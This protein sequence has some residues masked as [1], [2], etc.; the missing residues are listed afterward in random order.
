MT[1]TSRRRDKS[2]D[3]DVLV[4]HWLV[5]ISD[6]ATCNFALTCQDLRFHNFV[7]FAFMLFVASVLSLPYF[8]LQ[9]SHSCIVLSAC[10][11][12]RHLRNKVLVSKKNKTH[13]GQ[14]RQA[15]QDGQSRRHQGHQSATTA[16]GGKRRRAIIKL[17]KRTEEEI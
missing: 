10:V 8:H 6:F 5:F 13:E 3:P 4:S 17:K 9:Y 7:P 15:G 14:A 2:I 16:D 1:F 11:S 12:R